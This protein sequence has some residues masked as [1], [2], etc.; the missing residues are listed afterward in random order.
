M[1]TSSLRGQM[2]AGDGFEPPNV[3]Y[4]TT[5]LTT[6]RSRNIGTPFY[7]SA[8]APFLTTHFL[9]FRTFG[10]ILILLIY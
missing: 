5:D 2:G 8:G 6:S 4:E 7:I 10:I 1:F 9:S 3:D